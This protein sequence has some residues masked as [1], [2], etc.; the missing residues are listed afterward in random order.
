MSVSLTPLEGF[1][2]SILDIWTLCFGSL[3]ENLIK[4]PNIGISVSL[5]SFQAV[6]PVISVITTLLMTHI[7]SLMPVI[8]IKAVSL[9]RSLSTGHK[10]CA[11]LLYMHTQHQAAKSVCFQS[12][13][14]NLLICCTILQ[15][16]GMSDVW[17]PAAA[18]RFWRKHI[19]V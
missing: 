6:F 13:L 3:P 5:V 15:S 12:G 2:T 4:S 19:S 17:G 7:L 11:A 18:T 14:E 10:S 1:L 9:I 8:S 16:W